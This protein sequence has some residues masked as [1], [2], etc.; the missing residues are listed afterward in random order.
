MS[1][2]TEEMSGLGKPDDWQYLRLQQ[3]FAISI[4]PT[5]TGG[6]YFR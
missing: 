4:A 6:A 5:I 1:V 3:R 2:K